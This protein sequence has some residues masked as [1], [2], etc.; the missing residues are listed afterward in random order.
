VSYYIGL[1]LGGTN[2][3]GG[4]VDPDGNV[5]LEREIPTEAPGGPAHVIDRLGMLTKQMVQEA[6]LDLKKNLG[7]GVGTPG[8]LNDDAS[9]VLAAPNLH[10]WKN[11]PLR[12]ELAKRVG[13]PV[14]VV[15][16]ANAAAFGEYWSG[17]GR[18]HGIK[19]MV[20]LTLGTG[21]G[22][23]VVMQGRIFAGAHGAGTEMGHVIVVPNGKLCG[24][25]QRGCL[26]QYASATAVGTL[27]AE[28]IKAGGKKTNLPANPSARDVLVAMGKGD[29]L[30]V[31]V[32]D[33][34]C[35]YLG[36]AV[37]NF[38][39]IFDPQLMVLGG[40]MAFLG[41]TLLGR[42]RKVFEEQTWKVRPERVKIVAATL[43]NRAGF[44]GAAGMT[45]T[46]PLA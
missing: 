39:R 3:K 22:A 43:G 9:I 14:T 4:L 31:E 1:D 17:V 44:I 5:I 16:D 29:E 33:E 32:L 34:V 2:I 19:H 24:C 42:V 38:V 12:D 45:A 6:G 40:G 15:N 20:L 11:I 25:G 41:E 18:Q 30:A 7:L 21:I 27:A 36:L 10:G 8:P 23:G 26:E 35:T 13:V 37:V 46:A 28:K